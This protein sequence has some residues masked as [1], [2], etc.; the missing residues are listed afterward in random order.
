MDFDV[1]EVVATL[2]KPEMAD[3]SFERVAFPMAA[4]ER[5]HRKFKVVVEFASVAKT[6]DVL[7][8]L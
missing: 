8:S 7:E 4:F 6:R 1:A 3:D 5:F 2:R